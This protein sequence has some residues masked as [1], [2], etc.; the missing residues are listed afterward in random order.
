MRT[1]NSTTSAY[2]A[3][4]D[5]LNT[6]LAEW[7]TAWAPA[8]TQEQAKVLAAIGVNGILG[9][10]FATRLFHQSQAQ[11]ADDQYLAE[12]TEVLGA[13]IQTIGAD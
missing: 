6:E 3:L 13:R 2:A 10:R 7:I 9:A 1:S 8:T 12:W 5:T 11:V 4:V